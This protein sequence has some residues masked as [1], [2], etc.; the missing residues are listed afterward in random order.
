MPR[1][2]KKN[3]RNLNFDQPPRP[4]SYIDFNAKKKKNSTKW[5][6]MNNGV[7]HKTTENIYKSIVIL[8]LNIAG[9]GSVSPVTREFYGY[10]LWTFMDAKSERNHH[11]V[12]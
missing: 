7:F 5:V 2:P 6:L 1:K 11:V 9:K 4:K 3:H 8:N 12:T 10:L